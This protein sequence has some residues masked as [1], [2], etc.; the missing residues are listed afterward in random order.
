MILKNE[1]SILYS[2]GSDSTL[3]A[4]L[5]CEKFERIHLLTYYHRGIP[6]AEKSKI[7]AKRLANKFGKEKIK[8]ELIN[9]EEL[10]KKIHYDKYLFDLKRYKTYMTS[11]YCNACQL[12][13]HAATIMYNIKN[14]IHFAFDGYKREKQ[15]LYVFMTEEGIKETKEFYKEFKIEYDNPVY[16]IVRTDWELFDMGISPKK[17]VK[18]PSERLDFSTQHHCHDGIVTNAYLMG[19]FIPLYGQEASIKMSINYW[20]EKIKVMKSYIYNTMNLKNNKAYID[21]K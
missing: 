10:F 8:H 12:A 9:F 5:M 21:L 7:N 6:Y 18:F 2:G 3:V 20:K 19:Y 1:A 16:D 13:M 4:A 11:C 15:H 17:N 14:D